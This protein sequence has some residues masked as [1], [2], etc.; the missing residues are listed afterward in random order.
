[1]K[2]V[3]AHFMHESEM[4]AAQL[5]MIKFDQTE[6]Y[7]V[8]EIDENDIP[9]LQDAGIIIDFIEERPQVETPGGAWE[10]LPG[11][12]RQ[13]PQAA[14]GRRA[15]AI[16]DLTRPNF[17]LIQINGPLLESWRQQL[18]QLD[19]KLLEYVPHNHYTARLT[20]DQVTAVSQLE[21]VGGIRLYSPDDTQGPAVATRGGTPSPAGRQMMTYDA[22]LHREE[23][24]N[25]AVQ[26]LQDNKINIAGVS[27]RKIR[28]YLTEDDPVLD[29]IAAQPEIASIEQY[30]LPKLCNDVAR[31]LLGIDPP[32][33]AQS[34]LGLSQTGKGQIVAIADTGLDES[35]PDFQGRIVGVVALGRL[36]DPSDPNGHGT[37]VAGSVLGNGTASGGKIRGTAPEAELFFQS[38]LDTQDGLGGLPLNLEDLFEEAYQSGA[39]IHNN[40]WGSSTE[41][42]YTFSSLE[43]DEFVAKHR[44]ML[45]VIAAGN[46]GQAAKRFHSAQG[47]V[48]W[49]TINSPASAKNA[50]TVGASRTDRTSGG[51]TEYT[52]GQAFPDDF[53]DSPIADEKVSGNP[54]GLAAFSSR[55]PCDDRRIKPEVI[56]PGTDIV[57]TKSSRAPLRN[58]WGPY[59]SN[60]KYA[61]MGGTSMATPLVSGCAALI[62]E[63]YV[64]DLQHNP[65]AA[66]LKATIINSTHPLTGADA[67]ADHN[68]IPN[69][70]QGFGSV[71]MPWAIPNPGEP[72]LQLI[73]LDTWQDSSH[74]FDRN[75]QRFRFQ[76][77]CAGGA[78]LRFCLAWTDLPAR[79]LQNNLDLF[80]QHLPSGTKWVGNTDLPQKLKAT[81]P[82]NSVEVVRLDNPSAGNY[83]VQ[84][85]ASNLLQGPQDFALVITGKLTSP[86]TQIL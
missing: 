20:S 26:W 27:G 82:D 36:N 69:F 35:H 48:D 7:L 32:A 31:V 6:G 44:D 52:Y 80:V 24:A 47:Y 57:S 58:F 4:A 49:L 15:G 54:E 53:P 70:H 73:F 9:T 10:V 85:T 75:G 66:L 77:A 16:P 81:D 33:S 28:F 59:S 72:D 83:L 2:K 51:Y 21:F 43:V 5:R 63:Y 61:Y 8:G 55:G 18:T 71:Y 11:V 13:G 23:D 25:S 84:I 64:G 60:G 56:A 46:E 3:I 42:Q 79:A 12:Q 45:I 38:L 76:F 37:H 68:A 62:R 74:Q 39:R 19:V 17:Y 22:R 41:S 78:R 86:L 40:S 29:E 34:T 67:M 30:K 14:G 65:S 50:L 1:M